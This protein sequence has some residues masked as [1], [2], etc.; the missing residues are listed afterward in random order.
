MTL[1]INVLG[2]HAKQ[3]ASDVKFYLLWS[4]LYQELKQAAPGL[5]SAY[6]LFSLDCIVFLNKLELVTNIWK[7]RDFTLDKGCLWF[8]LKHGKF[9][10]C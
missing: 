10:Q 1:E 3:R 2:L 9:Q 8:Q 7:S 4:W 5:N 6:I